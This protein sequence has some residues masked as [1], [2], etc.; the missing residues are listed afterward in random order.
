MKA[1]A[2]CT[3]SGIAPRAAPG[4]STSVPY[5]GIGVQHELSGLPGAELGEAR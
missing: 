4:A 5:A 1:I 3:A 2:G